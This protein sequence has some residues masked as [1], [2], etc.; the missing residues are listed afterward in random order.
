MKNRECPYCGS[1]KSSKAGL[2]YRVK[3]CCQQY[4]C[5]DCHKVFIGKPIR[6]LEKVVPLIAGGE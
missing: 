6:Y 4:K 3:N 2:R 1:K 5:G